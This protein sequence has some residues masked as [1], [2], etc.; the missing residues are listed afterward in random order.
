MNIRT[1]L[2]S[3]LLAVVVSLITLGLGTSTTHAQVKIGD[4]APQFELK[5]QNGTTH[6]LKQHLGKVVVLEWVNPT[7]PFVVKHYNLKTMQTL[8][9][10]HPEVIWIPINSSY[11]TTDKDNAVWAKSVDVPY[12]LND[13]SGS[14]GK[15]Y[16]ARTTPHMY[17]IDPQGKIAYQGAIDDNPHFDERPAQNYVNAALTDLKMKRAVKTPEIKPY[18]CSVKYKR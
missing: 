17:V 11:Y 4:A 3:S 15:A 12:V 16:G 9:S 8:R 7:C 1:S 10:A 5:D 13:A 6:T 18:G 2:S 14:V